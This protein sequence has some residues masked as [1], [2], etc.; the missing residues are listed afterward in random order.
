MSDKVVQ[1]QPD[2]IERPSETPVNGQC[3]D[4]VP[5]YVADSDRCR[6]GFRDD[7]AHHSDLKSPTHSGMM[8]PG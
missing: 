5:D 1:M 6:P 2:P 4:A 7:L 3:R 8:S